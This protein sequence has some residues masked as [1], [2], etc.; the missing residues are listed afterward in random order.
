MQCACAMLS[1]VVCPALQYFSTLSHK[2]HDFRG[3]KK[4]RE[5]KMLGIVSSVTF[6]CDISIS[7]KN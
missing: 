6:V 1:Y 2:G 3:V 7:E 5:H 4:V